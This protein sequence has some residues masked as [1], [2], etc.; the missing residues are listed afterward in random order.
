MVL[1]SRAC[2]L[3][4]RLQGGWCK[5]QNPKAGFQDISYALPE[6]RFPA[7]LELLLACCRWPRRS[8]DSEFIRTLCAGPIDWQR[9]LQLVR[10]HRL[11]PLVSHSINLAI[12]PGGTA[13]VDA[14]LAELRSIAEMSTHRALR[15]L[16]ELRRVV[17]AF[18]AASIPTL[19][20][21]GIPLAQIVFGN[22][23]LRS[24][25]DLDLM[26]DQARIVEAD[27]VLRGLGYN[28]LFHID[29]FT[30]KRLEFYRTHWKD[31]TYQNSA[32]GQEVDLHWRCFRNR[33]MPGAG[34]CATRARE[35]VSF[36]D[37]QVQTLPETEG[38]LYL[39]VHGTLDGWLYFKSLVDVAAQVR[40]MD[41]DH[42]DMLATIAA[43][44][45]ILPELSAALHL[46]RRYL[47]MDRW[48]PLLLPPDDPTVGHILRYA[49]QTLVRGGY[50]AQREEIPISK[51][52]AFEGGL[53]HDLRY[54]RELLLRV[55]FR[56]RM[57]ET[58]PLPDWLFGLYPLLSPLEWAMYRF[59]Q[60]G[61]RAK[62]SRGAG[63]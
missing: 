8:D 20:L 40:T 61:S 45:G 43:E 60:G 26:I 27:E 48:S 37:F 42:L 41:V 6:R 36:G 11:V 4:I 33:A 3:W 10:H 50:L 63:L 2:Y 32:T 14:A 7:E 49:D 38:L 55:L 35:T 46:V 1:C 25:G 9:F 30:P 34:L 44:H 22:L 54:R 57:W 29:R 56:A 39:C 58:L 23:G 51:T 19:V 47:Q 18:G 59:R 62:G 28:G 15:S 31:L 5:L 21:K 53:R 13:E 12:E 24:P 52:L 17:H 16:A